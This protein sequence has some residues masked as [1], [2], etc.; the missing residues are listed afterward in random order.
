M[1]DF[2][3]LVHQE[4]AHITIPKLM[5]VRQ[6]LEEVVLHC[7][8]RHGEMVKLFKDIILV[9]YVIKAM[10]SNSPLLM[11]EL[12]CLHGLLLRTELTPEMHHLP[13]ALNLCADR[14]SRCRRYHNFMSELPAFPDTGGQRIQNTTFP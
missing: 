2:W 3:G 7:H 5:T 10:V 1:Q 9:V 11:A 4:K 8:L 12:R 6:A 14:F 13:S